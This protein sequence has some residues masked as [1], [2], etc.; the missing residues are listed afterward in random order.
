MWHE[1]FSLC[2]GDWF[3]AIVI[4]NMILTDQKKRSH[5]SFCFT[6]CRAFSCK[7]VSVIIS[8]GF[9]VVYRHILY[10]YYNNMLEHKPDKDIG[11]YNAKSI[12]T[13]KHY[14]NI[15]DSGRRNLLLFNHN[16]IMR[17]N[18]N[19]GW[20]DL[21]FSSL[22]WRSSSQNLPLLERCHLKLF[23]NNTWHVIGQTICLSLL[24]TW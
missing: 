1:C 24:I 2:K 10:W 5:L 14:T 9:T 7:L 6:L 22:S 4:H 3:W 11:H 8:C 12:W 16:S 21:A 18:S 20:E 23:S 17:S 13:P 15:L 19:G